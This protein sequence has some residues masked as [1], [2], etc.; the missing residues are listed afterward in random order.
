MNVNATNS[1]RPFINIIKPEAERY[2]NNKMNKGKH[3]VLYHCISLR[4]EY[5]VLSNE[6]NVAIAV[7]YFLVLSQKFSDESMRNHKNLSQD[8]LT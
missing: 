3:T 6:R 5:A 2:I 1:D 4:C 7:A 8:S